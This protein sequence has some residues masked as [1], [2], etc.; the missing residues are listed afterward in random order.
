MTAH[1]HDVAHDVTAHALGFLPAGGGDL[2]LLGALLLAGLVGGVTHC[3]GMCGPFVLAQV[4]MGLERVPAS[5]MRELS[6]L[7]APRSSPITWGGSPPTARW[8]R[9]RPRS[10]AS[11]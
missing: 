7:K 2:A 11:S 9:S 3:A 10:P 5:E 1:G 6:R 4:S 8:G